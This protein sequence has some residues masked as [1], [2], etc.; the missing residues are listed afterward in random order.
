MAQSVLNES[1]RRAGRASGGFS[2]ACRGT[3]G[4]GG[5]TFNRTDVR[6]VDPREGVLTGSSGVHPDQKREA[7]CLYGSFRLEKDVSRLRP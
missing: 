7:S 5:S 6:S 1:G 3:P 2:A 4:R